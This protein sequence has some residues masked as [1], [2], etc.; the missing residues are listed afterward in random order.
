MT[1]G[2]KKRKLPAAMI[3]Y[4]KPR[5]K[6][7]LLSAGDV[8]SKESSVKPISRDLALK[9]AGAE[10]MGRFTSASIVSR[11][12]NLDLQRSRSRRILNPAVSGMRPST[13][14]QTAAI[15]HR[16]LVMARMKSHDETEIQMPPP[17]LS[18]NLSVAS[19][20]HTNS[21]RPDLSPK[22]QTSEQMETRP[23]E[24]SARK[25][26]SVIKKEVLDGEE[27][28]SERSMRRF[29]R[30]RRNIETTSIA[31]RGSCCV[32]YCIYDDNCT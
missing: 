31:S 30:S 7:K 32:P 28:E 4:I 10:V 12:R 1:I 21:R 14:S 23:P 22:S 5:R 2:K 6:R 8:K 26:T 16:Q 11:Y 13:R 3:P 25:S 27:S 15:M 17:S 19:S 18:D 24:S 29:V 20:K 9:P